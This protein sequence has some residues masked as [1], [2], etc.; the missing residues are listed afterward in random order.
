[1]NKRR[2]FI[3]CGLWI[4]LLYVG[5]IIYVSPIARNFVH[6]YYLEGKG[7]IQTKSGL[8]EAPHN[9][10]CRRRHGYEMCTRGE[11]IRSA[12]FIAPLDFLLMTILPAVVIMTPDGFDPIDK[13]K[14]LVLFPPTGMFAIYFL[15]SLSTY[16]AK[17]YKR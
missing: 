2:L 15:I 7:S 6:S 8:S 1:M 3:A 9:W 16:A 4:V 10:G 11:A 5:S 12:T 13:V 17:R 14:I